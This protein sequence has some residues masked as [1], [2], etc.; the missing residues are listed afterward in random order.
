[1][2]SQAQ[3]V[4]TQARKNSLARAG[5]G[6]EGELMGQVAGRGKGDLSAVS[7]L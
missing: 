2:K 5:D 7:T 6:E 1:M 4:T 3:S